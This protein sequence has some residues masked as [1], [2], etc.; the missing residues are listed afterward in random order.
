VK[1]TE[2]PDIKPPESPE[3]TLLEYW[4]VIRRYLVLIIALSG[5]TVVA[6]LAVTVRTPRM[7]QSAATIIAPREVPG[8][9]LLAGLAASGLAQQVPG[10]AVP[11][12]SANRDV[13]LGI[14][15][16]RTMAE[17]VIR[18]FGLRE[19]YRTTLMQDTVRR[20]QSLTLIAVSRE[21]VISVAVEDTDPTLAAALANYHIEYLEDLLG[22]IGTGQATRQRVFIADQLAR[23]RGELEQQENRMRRFQERNRAIVLQEQT[24]GAIESAARLKG[25]IMAAEVQLQVLRN[26]ATESN[27]DVVSMRRRVDEMK[28]QLAQMQYGEDL[29]NRTRGSRGEIYVPFAKVPEVGMELARQTRDLKVQETLVTLLAQ[30][31]EQAKIAEAR[32]IPPVQLLDRAVPAE[33]HSRPS[34]RFNLTVAGPAGL[35]GSI[36]LAFLLDYVRGVSRSSRRARGARAA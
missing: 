36:F 11:S 16:S 32:D 33:R 23:A 29:S 3:P 18:K 10:L 14:L 27:P 7:Y 17:A 21:G 2:E 12:F 13:F 30:Q 20:L 1:A 5:A 35:V 28:R 24:R 9:G 22:R 4:T 6:T 8:G 31:L 15:K 26:F 19:R 25:E 34:L